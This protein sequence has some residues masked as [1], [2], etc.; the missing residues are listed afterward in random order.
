MFV[1]AKYSRFVLR[2]FNMQLPSFL[3]LYFVVCLKHGFFH[4]DKDMRYENTEQ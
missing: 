3:A 1:V 4:V 2:S